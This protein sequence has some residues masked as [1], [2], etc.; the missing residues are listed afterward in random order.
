MLARV[1][2]ERDDVLGFLLSQMG[3]PHFPTPIGVFR[4]VHRDTYETVVGLQ[5]DAARQR[6]GAGD[7][8]ALFSRGDTW[9]VA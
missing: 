5:L 9:S 1:H 3:P 7:L 4:A 6:Q 8:D 2:D